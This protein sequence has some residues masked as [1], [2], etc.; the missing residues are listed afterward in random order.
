MAETRLRIS[1]RHAFR[2]AVMVA[3]LA[4]PTCS[5]QPQVNLTTALSGIEKSRFLSCSGPPS[6]EIPEGGQDRM[7]FVSNL[8][9]GAMIGI[10]NPVADPAE[11][12]SVAATFE[13]SRLVSASFSGNQSMCQLV[14]APCL[15]Q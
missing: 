14:F 15:Q 7:W 4:L 9:R 8:R 11:S 10:T 2:H 3:A 5:Q 13:N 1:L 12:C 6:L